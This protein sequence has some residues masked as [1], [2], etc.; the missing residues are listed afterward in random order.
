MS[1]KN[2]RAKE[3]LHYCKD[4]TGEKYSRL[5]VIKYVYTKKKR[6]Y[7][8]CR[9]DCGNETILSTTAL[10][11]GNTKSCGCFQKEQLRK[12]IRKVIEGNIRYKTETEKTLN[13]KYRSIKRRCYNPKCEAYKNYGYR[14]IKM[15]D[16][17]LAD[18]KNFYNWAVNNGYKKG[19]TIDRIDVNGN[20]EPN[21]CRWISNLKQQ[22]NKRNNR[23]LIYNGK[24]MTCSEWARELNIPIGTISYRV[25]K[26]YKTE[27]ILKTN[28]KRRMNTDE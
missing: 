23:Y 15:C 10:K 7:W 5:T 8:L 9:C 22:N 16:E 6:A 14:G 17:W 27:D 19:L 13:L 20:Y 12:N 18:F 3:E 28:Y 25:S 1:G 21:N 2:R 24:K 11:S 4:I 26:G